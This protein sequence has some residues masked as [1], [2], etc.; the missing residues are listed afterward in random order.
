MRAPALAAVLLA[1]TAL[2]A[3]AAAAQFSF[4]MDGGY[5]TDRFDNGHEVTGAY[6]GGGLAAVVT[7]TVRESYAL[8]IPMSAEMRL[9]Q[10][11]WM[12]AAINADLMLRLGSVAV[13]AGL[14]FRAP[15]APD[16]PDQAAGDDTVFVQDVQMFGY[17]GSARLNLGP[18]GRAFVQGRVSIFPKD[19]GF[20]L[21]DECSSEYLGEDL[22]A[23]CRSVSGQGVPVYE[24]AA[25][26]RVALG[27]VFP[28]GGSARTLRLQW[29]HQ[30]FD[31]SLSGDNL[32]GAYNRDAD[33][34]T[35]GFVFTM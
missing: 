8:L 22:E 12:D 6:A 4:W 20:D 11:G 18:Q 34:L 5:R 2:N 17:S 27:Y 3:P 29:T 35:L 32:N 23:A 33:Y 28:G 1:A 9:G 15:S 30:R 13:G 31:Y 25:E 24:G 21:I 7:G 14:D 26:A 19:Y 16:V 10:N